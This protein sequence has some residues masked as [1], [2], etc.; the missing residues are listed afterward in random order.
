MKEQ[1]QTILDN[2]VRPML[3]SH[4]G[5]VELVDVTEDGIVTV[6]LQGACAGCAGARATLQGVVEENLK[7]QCPEVKEVRADFS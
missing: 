2:D 4:G 3:Q 1:V 5:D 7:K 6:K